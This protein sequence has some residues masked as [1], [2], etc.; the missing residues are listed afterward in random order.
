MQSQVQSLSSTLGRPYDAAS[1]SRYRQTRSLTVGSQSMMSAL[2]DHG[3]SST[4]SR[5]WR[6]R[7]RYHVR[8]HSDS[9]IRRCLDGHRIRPGAHAVAR[10][11][12]GASTRSVACTARKLQ[13]RIVYPGIAVPG[14]DYTRLR[15][16]MNRTLRTPRTSSASHHTIW[17]TGAYSPGRRVGNSNANIALIAFDRAL[18]SR[19]FRR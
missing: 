10:W 12:A 6:V 2:L 19:S 7:R 4:Y 9:E 16:R 8:F 14:L 5:D 1:P 18:P 13:S 17:G 15:T 3:N 11:V